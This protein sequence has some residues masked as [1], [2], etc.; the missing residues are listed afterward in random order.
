MERNLFGVLAYQIAFGGQCD[1]YAQ[2]VRDYVERNIDFAVE[3]VHRRIPEIRC[4]KPQA[5]FLLWLDCSALGFQT[6][7]E[8]DEFFL[9]N[10]KVAL[11][12][13]AAFGK[14]GEQHVRMNLACPRTRVAEALVRI[15]AAVKS[16][17][18]LR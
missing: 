11:N 8:L 12:S 2:A 15:E 13:G 10:A 17:R 18:P 1:D 16:L 3:F 14:E 7:A 9:R 5:T 6:Q 4:V